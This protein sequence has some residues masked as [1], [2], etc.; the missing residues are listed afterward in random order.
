MKIR[1]RIF[2]AL[3]GTPLAILLLGAGLYFFFSEKT[4][5]SAIESKLLTTAEL[6]QEHVESVVAQNL[7]RLSLISSRTQLRLSLREYLETGSTAA[8]QK[9]SDIALD[10]L[11]AV[12]DF[13][14]IYIADPTGRVV[15]SS[16]PN[17]LGNPFI[18]PAIAS[19]ALQHNL[20]NRSLVYGGQPFLQ[21]T[22]PLQLDGNVIGIVAVKSD[23]GVFRR[24]AR[25]SPVVGLSSETLLV[26]RDETGELFAVTNRRY[27][28]A[29][30]TLTPMIDPFKNHPAS[31]MMAMRDYR[32]ENVLAVTKVLEQYDWGLTVKVDRD[33]ALQPLADLR[34]YLLVA[35]AI[36]SALSI[37]LAS[38]LSRALIGPVRSLTEVAEAILGGDLKRRIALEQQDELGT[39]GAAFN[40]MADE[41]VAANESLKRDSSI[42]HLTQ[43]PNRRMFDEALHQEWNRA[44]RNQNMLCLLMV[45]I[46]HFKEYNDALGH[47][48]GDV[49]LH[50]VA[51]L[52]KTVLHRPGDLVA[53][54]GGEEFVMLLSDSGLEH[55]E[56]FAEKVRRA[57]L[58]R[59][60]PHPDNEG[61]GI[62][63]ISIGVAGA[64]PDSKSSP[65]GLLQRADDALY[66]AKASGRNRVETVGKEWNSQTRAAIETP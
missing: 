48:N 41:L 37:L 26:T 54:Y 11:N 6:K 14:Q 38:L 34:H 49:C 39:L 18:Y 21:L 29:A 64:V 5:M 7:E 51:S 44:Q 13:R 61:L 27:A 24:I 4:L 31:G 56:A 53:R 59:A 52:L 20:A 15:V 47:L 25:T 50:R 55:L 36:A 57:V 8:Q 63:T 1:S 23:I 60:I 35:I 10:A 32:G 2:F 17:A 19:E 66:R 12:A 42:D 43:L 46:D 45:D 33:E 28:D 40:R 16:D 9:V 3:L 22:G 65:A 58:D 30:N 62:V